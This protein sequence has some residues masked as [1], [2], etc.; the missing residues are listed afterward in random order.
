MA[1]AS[2]K[3][4]KHWCRDID[5]VTGGVVW[6]DVTNVTYGEC[7]VTFTNS[8]ITSEA[9]PCPDGLVYAEPADHSMVSQVG[10]A[11]VPR[12]VSLLFKYV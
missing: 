8:S 9:M 7:T 1:V 2:G 12:E 11:S 5:N 10:H 6:D 3:A 4:N